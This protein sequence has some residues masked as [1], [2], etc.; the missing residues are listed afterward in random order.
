MIPVVFARILQFEQPAMPSL[1]SSEVLLVITPWTPLPEWVAS[2][3]KLTPGV[4]VI[5]HETAMY[6]TELPSEISPETW[7]RVTVL[8]TW[9]L[10]PTK[11][12]APNLKYVQLQSAGC[13]QALGLPIFEE[14]DIAF[15]T[16]NGVHPPQIAEWVFATFLSFQHHSKRLIS[17]FLR[18]FTAF[19][20]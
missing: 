5:T 10:L 18:L 6:A 15:C 9:K 17:I 1:Q 11:E 13:N 2:L 19:V 4:E 14:T 8:L 20:T 3:E 12:Q 16:A 7:K